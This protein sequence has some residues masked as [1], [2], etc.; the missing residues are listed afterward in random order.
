[1]NGSGA[2]TTGRKPTT[3]PTLTS[4]YKNIVKLSVP[5]KIL[6]KLSV[7]FIEILIPRVL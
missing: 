3:M 7:A 5:V 4:T 2:P 6:P 1:M